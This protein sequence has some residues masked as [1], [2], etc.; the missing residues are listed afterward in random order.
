MQILV[1]EIQGQRLSY[2]LY[3]LDSASRLLATG[4][5][6]GIGDAEGAFFHTNADLGDSV[7][8]AAQFPSWRE[9]VCAML[10]HLFGGCIDSLEDIDAVAVAGQDSGATDALH[11]MLPHRA[12]FPVAAGGLAAALEAAAL[13]RATNRKGE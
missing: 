8:M 11:S 12:L 2:A 4:S 9:A 3:R 5:A 6:Q 13:L 7:R 1:C 10:E